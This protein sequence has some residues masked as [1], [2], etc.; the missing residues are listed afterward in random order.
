MLGKMHY[1][2]LQALV[3]LL[4]GIDTRELLSSVGGVKLK[5]FLDDEKRVQNPRKKTF[6]YFIFDLRSF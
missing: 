6:Y 1:F 3:D 5:Q 2:I 4:A